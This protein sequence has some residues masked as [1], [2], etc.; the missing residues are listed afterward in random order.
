MCLSGGNSYTA[1]GLQTGDSSRQVRRVDLWVRGGE[2]YED[3]GSRRPSHPRCL[4]Y[5]QVT[6]HP[7]D[8]GLDKTA[9]SRLFINSQDSNLWTL[10][11]NKVCA[12]T[13]GLCLLLRDIPGCPSARS[14]L[15]LSL[16]SSSQYKQ[17]ANP[18]PVSQLVHSTLS[19]IDTPSSAAAEGS[20]YSLP[21]RPFGSAFTW[22]HH[23][24]C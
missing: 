11:F 16:L 2:Q 12:V 13:L 3:V 17:S 8:D 21:E 5:S 18:L 20:S 10:I 22:G 15:P 7:F 9:A 6:I 14:L 4:P 24:R 23:S 19:H 1:P